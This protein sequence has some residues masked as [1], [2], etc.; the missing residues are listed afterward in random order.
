MKK[1]FIEKSDHSNYW[2]QACYIKYIE[3]LR[4]MCACVRV[5]FSINC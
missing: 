2:E 3:V 4:G 5:L 1:K